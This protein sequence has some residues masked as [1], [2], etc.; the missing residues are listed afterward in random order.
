MLKEWKP[1]DVLCVFLGVGMMVA[2]FISIIA[3]AITGRE[4]TEAGKDVASEV[5]TGFLYIVFLYAT[6]AI[7][8]SEKKKEGK[9]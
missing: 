2:I 3:L 7:K 1:L 6:H 4:M 5:L 8:S 9:E